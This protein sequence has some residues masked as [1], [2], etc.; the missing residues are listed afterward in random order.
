MGF[1]PVYLAERK[2][3]NNDS[4]LHASDRADVYGLVRRNLG[5]HGC[6]HGGAKQSG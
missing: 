2:E 5:F 3:N 6:D 1:Q 4:P